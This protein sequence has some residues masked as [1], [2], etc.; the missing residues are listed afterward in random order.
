MEQK[1]N[2]QNEQFKKTIDMFLGEVRTACHSMI[3]QKYISDS[4]VS[5]V[6]EALEYLSEHYEKE[7]K[8]GN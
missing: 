7:K 6:K 8:E 5:L 1:S 2:N 4:P 3:D